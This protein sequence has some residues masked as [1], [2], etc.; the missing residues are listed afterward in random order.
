ML[1]IA[2]RAGGRY[3]GAERADEFGR[4]NGVAGELVVRIHPTK[5]TEVFDIVE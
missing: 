3:T 1:D 2:T 5:V 4:R